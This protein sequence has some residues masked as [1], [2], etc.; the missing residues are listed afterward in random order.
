MRQFKRILILR[1]DRLGDVVL[2]TPVI[3]SLRKNY[4]DCYIAFLCR[5]YTHQ[6]LEGNP[7]LD[8]VIVYDK[9]GKHKS[10]FATLRFSLALR[11]EKFDLAIV[12]HPT[13]RAHLLT[14][15]AGIPQRVGWNRK[16]GFL[17]TNKLEHKK[18]EGKKHELEY[19]FD[20]LK[21]TG[22]SSKDREIYVPLR[23]E[24]EARIKKIL[25]AKGLKEKDNLVVIHPS[26]SCPS[27]RWPQANFLELIS[28]LKKNEGVKIALITSKDQVEFGEMISKKHKLMDLRGQLSISE[29]ASLLAKASLFIS[30]DSG[31]VHIAC[32]LGVPVISIFGRSQPG[33][34]PRRWGPAGKNSYFLHRNLGCTPCLAHNCL[35]KIQCLAAIKP[36]EVYSLAKK[37]LFSLDSGKKD[38]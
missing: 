26:A 7:Y 30:C 1:T 16:L 38:N 15:F 11:K 25:N 10:W 36:Q 37:V 14:F 35:K 29:T 23:P 6:A 3:K 28:L 19:N 22:I 17:L 12:L 33:L 2:S 18:D 34:S 9:Y 21:Y 13:N 5:P 4:P 8:K 32:G 24:A 31:P 20:L 27:K